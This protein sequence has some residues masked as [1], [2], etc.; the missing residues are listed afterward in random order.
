MSQPEQDRTVSLAEAAP[1]AIT[2]APAA[3]YPRRP[4]AFANLDLL[5]LGDRRALESRWETTEQEAPAILLHNLG[6]AL[7]AP[8][9]VVWLPDGRVVAESL[10]NLNAASRAASLAEPMPQAPDH[11]QPRR[12]ALLLVRAGS[13]NY[14]H[15]LAEHL[16]ALL[17]LGQVRPGL[18]AELVVADHRGAMLGVVEEGVARAGFAPQ[19][20]RRLPPRGLH[21][22][23][24]L[25]LSPASIHSYMKHPAAIEALAGLAPPRPAGELLFVRRTSVAKRVLLNIDPVEEMALSL[26]FRA[27]EPGRMSFAEQIE[28]FAAARVVV[29]VSGA[30]L[31]NIVFMPPGGDVVCLL[32][33]RGREFF[34]WDL[35]CLR[36]H[37]YWS[38]FGAPETDRGGGHDD[39]TVDVDLTRSVLRQALA[40]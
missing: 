4:P 5:D 6:E 15:F 23:E 37:R 21:L 16:G 27:I 1:G 35:C 12:P 31:T 33:T 8:P 2:I 25:M 34:F 32:P 40:G 30:D 26:G 22:Q 3:I 14:G 39:F 19:A 13:T 38:I 29:G 9:G 36:D 17:L 11:P 20:L 18:R 24:V 7:A 28:A 10:H